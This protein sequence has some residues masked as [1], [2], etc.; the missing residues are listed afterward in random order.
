V[1]QITGQEVLQ[2]QGDCVLYKGREYPLSLNNG[3]AIEHIKT[4]ALKFCKGLGL[5]IGA[6]KWPLEGAIPIDISYGNGQDAT[7]LNE[8]ANQSMDFI[9]SSHCLE[10]IPENLWEDALALWLKKLKIGGY[11]ALYL[12]HPEMELWH[13]GAPWVG[14]AHKWIPTL[15]AISDFFELHFI[16]IVDQ[17]EGPDSYFSFFIVGRKSFD[18][19]S[20]LFND[21]PSN[22]GIN[23]QQ[24][25]GG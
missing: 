10:H 2:R 7:H 13:P 4:R 18:V 22:N 8:Y 21:T 1:E 9:F 17:F 19:T 3:N 12:P 15:D 23:V 14:D 24:C 11:I 25:G 6:G 20:T 16:E 5:D